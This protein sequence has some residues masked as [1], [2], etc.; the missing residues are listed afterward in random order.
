MIVRSAVLE[1]TVASAGREGFD[2]HMRT[3]VLAAIA[4][5]PGLRD[6]R[7]RWPVETEAGAPP[8]YCIFDLYFDSVAAMHAALASPTREAVRKS[9]GEVMAAFSGKVY[10]LV[11]DETAGPHSR[12]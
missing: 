11:V 4:R 2:N 1:G 3:T 8:V 7:L 6:V 12:A 5:Y 10:H 9:I